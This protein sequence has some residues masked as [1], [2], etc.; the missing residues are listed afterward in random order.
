[1]QIV[2]DTSP[3]LILKRGGTLE[4]KLPLLFDDYENEVAWR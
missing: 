2:S 3:L 4:K 1:M